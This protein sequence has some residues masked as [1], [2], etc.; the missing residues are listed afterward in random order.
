MGDTLVT[1]AAQVF[2]DRLW[3][4]EG[5]DFDATAFRATDVVVVMVDVAVPLIAQT[6]FT[7]VDDGDDSFLRETLQAPEQGRSIEVHFL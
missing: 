4:T 5:N 7:E 6:P 1:L 2:Q 3:H